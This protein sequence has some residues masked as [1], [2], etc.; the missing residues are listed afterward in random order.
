MRDPTR[1]ASQ[2]ESCD[3]RSSSA[4]RRGDRGRYAAPTSLL[5]PRHGTCNQNARLTPLGV[6]RN[7]CTHVLPATSY[8]QIVGMRYPTIATTRLRWNSLPDDRV[9]DR[10]GDAAPSTPLSPRRQE[11]GLR[12]APLLRRTT[13]PPPIHATDTRLSAA[14]AL[15]DIHSHGLSRPAANSA[16]FELPRPVPSGMDIGTAEYMGWTDN[17]A[18]ATGV[19]VNHA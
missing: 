10:C 8:S 2:D 13:V 6:R 4:R 17:G 9:A 3:R 18:S 14:V 7:T 16:L 1:Q 5:V 15:E 12:A 19:A 11:G